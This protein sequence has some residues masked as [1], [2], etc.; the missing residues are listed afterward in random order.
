[1]TQETP[2]TLQTLRRGLYY[3]LY[4]LHSF[5]ASWQKVVDRHGPPVEMEAH[6]FNLPF[7]ET[8]FGRRI[9]LVGILGAT[10]PSTLSLAFFIGDELCHFAYG[11]HPTYLRVIKGKSSE[12]AG[13]HHDVYFEIGLYDNFSVIC[14]GCTDVEGSHGGHG[15]ETMDAVFALLSKLSGIEIQTV[16]LPFEKYNPLRLRL[17]DHV[18]EHR[19]TD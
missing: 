4:A 12:K 15:K 17:I 6:P 10:D 3:L 7:P 8:R 14:G 5:D 1:M 18:T 19:R 9:R 13:S 2:E 16:T 11:N